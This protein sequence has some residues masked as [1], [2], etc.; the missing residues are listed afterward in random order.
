MYLTV[1]E[2]VVQGKIPEFIPAH[3]KGYPKVIPTLRYFMQLEGNVVIGYT[4]YVDMGD[5]YFV[6]NTYIRPESRGQGHYKNLLKE[7][8]K[9][10]DDKPKI[11]LVNPIQGTDINILERQVL[12]GGGI[13][14]NSYTQV[15]HIMGQTVYDGMYH[16]PMYM[17]R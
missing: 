4:C 8:N 3:E 9:I 13:K 10:L 17:Y 14:I 15:E 7:R 1:N 5:F 6:G 2:K 12:R 11:T 16:L